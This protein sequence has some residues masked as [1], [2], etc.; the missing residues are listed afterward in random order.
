M[1]FIVAVLITNLQRLH[2]LINTYGKYHWFHS[3]PLP[4]GISVC[5]SRGSYVRLTSSWK[6]PFIGK[7][8]DLW[9]FPNNGYSLVSSW[10]RHSDMLE[11]EQQNSKC[12]PLCHLVAPKTRIYWWSVPNNRIIRAM[13]P[14]NAALQAIPTVPW[15]A[16]KGGI[17]SLISKSSWT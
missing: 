7:R 2:S 1:L 17:I 3:I 14:R 9:L 4:I 10:N 13:Y 16:F 6:V 8:F 5:A 11:L 15:S 12:G